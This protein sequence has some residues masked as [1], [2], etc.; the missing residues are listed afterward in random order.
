MQEGFVVVERVVAA[1]G[2]VDRLRQ[3][4]GEILVGTGTTPSSGQ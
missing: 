4:D 2:V 3:A 1:A